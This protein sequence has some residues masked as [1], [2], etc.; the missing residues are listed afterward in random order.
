LNKPPRCAKPNWSRKPAR[1]IA[2]DNG[3]KLR[4][5][6]DTRALVLDVFSTPVR[7]HSMPRDSD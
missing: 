1:V 5:L 6:S 2:L 3:T 7:A 4:T